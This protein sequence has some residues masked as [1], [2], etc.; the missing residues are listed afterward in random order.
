MVS[1]FI[2]I[3]HLLRSALETEELILILMSFTYI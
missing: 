2:Y 1:L 3:V